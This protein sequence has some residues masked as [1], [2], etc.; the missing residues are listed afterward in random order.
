MKMEK[1]KQEKPESSRMNCCR[2][3][4]DESIGS[5][6]PRLIPRTTSTFRF[7]ETFSVFSKDP[8]R[9][10]RVRHGGCFL[11]VTE[12]LSETL[13][14]YLFLAFSPFITIGQIR[15]DRKQSGREIGGCDQERS[16]RQDS[17]S[18]RP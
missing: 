7:R 15:T 1:L 10:E 5:K 8:E 6:N 17:N 2:V 14:K 16:L 11:H 18:G 13:C 3:L 9:H 12:G 4:D